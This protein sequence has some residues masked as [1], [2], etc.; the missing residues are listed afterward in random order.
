MFV[1]A[2]KLVECLLGDLV[3][4]LSFAASVPS[5]VSTPILV[6]L[7]LFAKLL[8]LATSPL[9]IACGSSL[10]VFALVLMFALYLLPLTAICCCRH[11]PPPSLWIAGAN[12][13]TIRIDAIA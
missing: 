5:F 9:L 4:T 3:S 11:P 8:S 13:N 12:L 1:V 7:C 6:G 10:S 2:A